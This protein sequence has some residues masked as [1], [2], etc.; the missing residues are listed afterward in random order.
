MKSFYL[1]FFTVA[2]VVSCMAQRINN[3]TD[4]Q[5]AFIHP[6]E[7]IIVKQGETYS[8]F[9][10]HAVFFD[11]A[12]KYKPEFDLITAE[13]LETL[14]KDPGNIYLKDIK[15]LNPKELHQTAFGIKGSITMRH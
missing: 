12:V 6:V 10:V 2:V 14:Q 11:E 9:R 7:G 5:L 3:V 13:K 1:F 8:R 15:P 4:A